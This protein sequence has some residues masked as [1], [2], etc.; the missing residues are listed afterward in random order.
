MAFQSGT[1]LTL[2]CN[3]SEKIQPKSFRWFKSGQHIV[4]ATSGTYNKANAATGDSG[5]YTCATENNLGWSPQS[6]QFT[7]VVSGKQKIVYYVFV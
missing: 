5:V 7:I 1:T 4:G 2:K 6:K 3:P